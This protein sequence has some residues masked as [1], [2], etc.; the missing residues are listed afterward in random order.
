[1]ECIIFAIHLASLV[2]FALSTQGSI[3]LL[4]LSGKI[5]LCYIAVVCT[6]YIHSKGTGMQLG[7][8]FSVNPSPVFKRP[9]CAPFTMLEM[10]LK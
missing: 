3:V 7:Y 4:D 1:M 10:V 6:N 8:V 2:L 5:K 9:F